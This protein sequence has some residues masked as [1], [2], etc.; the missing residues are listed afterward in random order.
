LLGRL[1]AGAVAPFARHTAWALA[2]AFVAVT[3]VCWIY[4]FTTPIVF[5][6]LIAACLVGAAWLTPAV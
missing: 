4:S 2:G 6:T 1:P 5:S 3:A